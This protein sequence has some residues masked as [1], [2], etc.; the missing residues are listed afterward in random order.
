MLTPAP[1]IYEVF[2]LLKTLEAL[3]SKY[4]NLQPRGIHLFVI[5]AKSR[6]LNVYYNYPPQNLSRFVYKMTGSRPH[7][8]LLLE[9][10]TGTRVV[11]DAKYRLGVTL[12]AKIRGKRL[13]LK[14]A[15]RLLG[16]LADLAYNNVLHAILA[17][18]RK[19]EES[20]SLVGSLDG[21]NVKIDIAEVNPS[22]GAKELIQLLP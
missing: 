2:V 15:L 12:S 11:V 8:D 14:E 7:P 1:K 3:K 18:P 16:Y 4:G 20:T 10:P 22:K 19:S 6:K 21:T 5:E 13:E 17:V 9:Y